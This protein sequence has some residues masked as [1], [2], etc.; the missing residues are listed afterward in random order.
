MLQTGANAAP[1]F[2]ILDIY[3]SISNT[4]FVVHSPGIPT[5]AYGI[6][7][8]VLVNHSQYVV[9]PDGTKVKVFFW[10]KEIP[11]ALH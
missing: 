4:Y 10:F 3:F 8:F 1:I 9:M 11:G 5:L 7:Q 6:G 2:F